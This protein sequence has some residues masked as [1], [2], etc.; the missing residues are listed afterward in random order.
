LVRV[1]KFIIILSIILFSCCN[2]SYAIESA[3]HKV[4]VAKCFGVIMTIK[5]NSE[6][7]DNIIKANNIL[8]LY[9]EKIINL[10]IGSL[11]MK[12]MSDEA[13]IKTFSEL[14][15]HTPTHFDNLLN[16]CIATLRIG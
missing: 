14:Q 10:N 8:E 1:E 9:L 3:A 12:E 5:N 7:E 4:E 16:K 11:M 6:H 15:S 2:I 13:A